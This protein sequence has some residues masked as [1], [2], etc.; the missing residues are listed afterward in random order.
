MVG[1]GSLVRR[2]AGTKVRTS[3][4]RST[5]SLSDEDS[6]TFC[7]FRRSSSILRWCFGSFWSSSFCRRSSSCLLSAAACLRSP[8]PPRLSTFAAELCR[9]F[10][11]LL[12]SFSWKVSFPAVVP[13]EGLAG[14]V[15]RVGLPV[16][17]RMVSLGGGAGGGACSVSCSTGRTAVGRMAVG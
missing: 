12:F 13:A 17:G 8:P 15:G 7:S 10:W 1:P 6:I 4:L 9:N 11:N 5:L 14:L 2:C 16:G 3:V